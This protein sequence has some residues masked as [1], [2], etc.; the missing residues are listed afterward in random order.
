M[1]TVEKILEEEILSEKDTNE[2][3]DII[4]Y[5]SKWKLFKLAFFSLSIFLL[6]VFILG[7]AYNSYLEQM[8]FDLNL[9]IIIFVVFF[10]FIISFPTLLYFVNRLIFPKP[11]VMIN[12]DGIFDNSTAFAVGMIQWDEIAEIF[13]SKYNGEKYLIIVPKNKRALLSRFGPIKRLFILNG[14]SEI[15]IPEAV[16]SI[17]IENLLQLIGEYD[18]PKIRNNQLL[19]YK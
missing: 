7:I 19:Q 9:I 4:I 8:K 10:Y 13:N 1:K 17:S 18:Y 14:M 15:W 16:L 12:D 3:Q 6:G 5:P 2:N 11:L